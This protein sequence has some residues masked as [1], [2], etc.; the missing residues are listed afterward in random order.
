MHNRPIVNNNIAG[1]KRKHANTG[2]EVLLVLDIKEGKVIA[3]AETI[4][5]DP[6]QDAW[7]SQPFLGRRTITAQNVRDSMKICKGV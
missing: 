6:N 2:Y 3:K 7:N 1:Y 4:A 5:S